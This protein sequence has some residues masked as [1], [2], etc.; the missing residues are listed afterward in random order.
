MSLSCSLTTSLFHNLSFFSLVFPAPLG[1]FSQAGFLSCCVLHSL[2]GNTTRSQGNRVV[3]NY[4][5]LYVH[6]SDGYWILIEVWQTTLIEKKEKK[7]FLTS[8]FSSLRIDADV[9]DLCGK[10]LQSQGQHSEERKDCEGRSTAGHREAIRSTD[11][12]TDRVLRRVLCCPFDASVS[13]SMRHFAIVK[14]Q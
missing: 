7:M 11:K 8:L 3:T 10:R 12:V 4:V 5:H 13:R 1:L 9:L 2:W 14:L 6:F